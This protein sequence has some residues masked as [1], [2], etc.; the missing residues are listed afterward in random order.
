[1]EAEDEEEGALPLAPAN[2]DAEIRLYA[3]DPENE[4]P[5]DIYVQ[6]QRKKGDLVAYGKF[7]KDLM[8]AGEL[9]IFVEP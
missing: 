8:D 5:E 1:M 7:V 2:F 9:K 4:E 3:E 6:I